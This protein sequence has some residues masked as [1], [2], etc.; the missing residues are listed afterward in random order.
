MTGLSRRTSAGGRQWLQYGF[1]QNHNNSY[2]I[3]D[4]TSLQQK[5]QSSTKIMV[6]KFATSFFFHNFYA[7]SRNQIELFADNIPDFQIP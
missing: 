7:T 3:Q 5:F 2:T 1:P 6:Q 4:P